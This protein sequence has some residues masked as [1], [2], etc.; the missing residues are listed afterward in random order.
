MLSED[1]QFLSNHFRQFEESGANLRPKTASDL[2][3]ALK[4]M[5]CRARLLEA[6]LIPLHGRNAAKPAPNVLPFRRRS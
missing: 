4:E 2:S 1:L 6:L 5:A 3:A